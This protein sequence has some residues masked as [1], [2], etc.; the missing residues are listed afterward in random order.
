MEPQ[1][2]RVSENDPRVDVAPAADNT[3][4]GIA[5]VRASPQTFIRSALI[6]VDFDRGPTRQPHPATHPGFFLRREI[7]KGKRNAALPE[8]DDDDTSR[9]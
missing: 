1:P 3:A 7:A 9:N 2:H 6:C 4:S 8:D 5:I